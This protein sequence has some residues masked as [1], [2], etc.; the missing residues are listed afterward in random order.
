MFDLGQV[1]LLRRCATLFAMSRIFRR[2]CAYL[3]IAALTFA[4]L[5]ISAYACPMN[6][7]E[8][9]SY[10]SDSSGDDCEMS[11]SSNL[12]ER[13]CDYGASS[14]QASP[15]PAI[16]PQ[17][18]LSPLRIPAFVA[19]SFHTSAREFLPPSRIEPPPLVRFGVLRI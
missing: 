10:A 5:A 19:L 7:A 15:V 2:I 8:S 12:C 18:V 16:A 3:A 6:I 14:V 4:Q 11:G 17:V 13:H 1:A 9:A